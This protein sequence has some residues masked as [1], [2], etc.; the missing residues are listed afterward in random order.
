[1]DKVIDKLSAEAK[2]KMVKAYIDFEKSLPNIEER[3]PDNSSAIPNPCTHNFVMSIGR[4]RS[5][6]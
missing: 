4:L 6:K 2:R 5:Q 1:M 3:T